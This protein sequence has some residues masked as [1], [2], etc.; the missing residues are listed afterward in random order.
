MGNTT[1]PGQVDRSS[2]DDDFQAINLK[3]C[4]FDD[5]P[6]LVDDHVISGYGVLKLS[7]QSSRFAQITSVFL[8]THC[9][10]GRCI[11]RT[12][13]AD[14]SVNEWSSDNQCDR[15]PSE[16]SSLSIPPARGAR[17]P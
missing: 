3:S 10:M 17:L 8:Q 12:M 15:Q 14:D 4:C 11:D 6:L 2:A 16:D 7:Q 1:V 5:I 13:D 9:N